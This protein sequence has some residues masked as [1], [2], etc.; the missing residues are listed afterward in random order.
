[1]PLTG[2]PGPRTETISI[3]VPLVMCVVCNHA[4]PGIPVRFENGNVVEHAAPKGW[5]R[6]LVEDTK[7][8]GDYVY[9]CPNKCVEKLPT[10]S[11][12]GDR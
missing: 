2:K 9:F 6:A 12:F 11:E 10:I 7:R 3:E 5:R 8:K 1:M 4:V